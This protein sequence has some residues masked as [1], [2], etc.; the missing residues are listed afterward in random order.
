MQFM[1]IVILSIFAV[2]F[3]SCTKKSST[4]DQVTTS[5]K[6]PQIHVD[7]P[8]QKS[9]KKEPDFSKTLREAIYFSSSLEREALKLILKNPSLQKITLFSSLAYIVEVNSGAKKTP[10]FGLDCGTY[11]IKRENNKILI[12]KSCV[13]PAPKVAEVDI[14]RQDESYKVHFFISEWSA[15]VG[16]SVALTGSDMSCD[17]GIK[18]KKL[19]KLIC[20]NWSY[21]TVEDQLSSTVL[22]AQEF[23]FQRDSQKQFVIK[24]AFY[25]ELVEN[26]KF[27]VLV[28]LEGKIKIIEKEVQIIDEFLEDIKQQQNAD[29]GTNGEESTT[30]SESGSKEEVSVEDGRN[31]N[32]EN[33]NQEGYNQENNGQENPYGESINPNEEGFSAPGLEFQ[34]VPGQTPEQNP[35]LIPSEVPQDDVPVQPVPTRGRGR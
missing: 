16:M 15:V 20:N 1:K 23:K 5:Q 32:Q 9:Q 25:K 7:K 13:K 6:D 21:Q 34:E 31:Q 14:I 19:H 18:E 30:Q 12:F 17:L 24:G 29:G 28:P 11:D 27:D 8:V 3:V 35:E 26:R 2:F 10:P 4:Q 22:K 33:S